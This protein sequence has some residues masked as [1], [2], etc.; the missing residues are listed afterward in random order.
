MFSSAIPL[1]LTEF[2]FFQ[3]YKS[4]VWWTYTIV[5]QMIHMTAKCPM[6]TVEVDGWNDTNMYDKL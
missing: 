4:S 2:W 6:E 5:F 3:I 1:W